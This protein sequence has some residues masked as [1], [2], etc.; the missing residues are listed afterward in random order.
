MKGNQN[1]PNKQFTSNDMTAKP[2]PF[3]IALEATVEITVI[4]KDSSPNKF[5]YSNSKHYYAN[6][7]FKPPSRNGSP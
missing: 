7:N 3:F 2:L 6:S 4:I 5:P 1:L